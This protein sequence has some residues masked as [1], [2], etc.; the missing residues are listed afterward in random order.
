MTIEILTTAADMVTFS[1]EAEAELRM[2]FHGRVI[3]PNDA[4]YDEARMVF[5]GM[6]DRRPGL[7]IQCSGSADV[8][9]AV[10]FAR[11]HR[12][13]T[14]V[15]GGAHSIAGF[16]A[17]DRGLVID[18]SAMRG[19]WVD[20]VRRV[21]R[22]QGGATWGDVD[23]ETQRVG[24]VV[25]GGVISTPG[26]AGLTLGGGLG[27]VHR[28]FGLSC[29]NLRAVEVVTA[30]GQLIRASESE[31]ADLFWALRGGGGNFGIAT[32]FE[33]DAHVMGPIVMS[34]SPVYPIDQ[35]GTV[36]RGWRDWAMT[37][38]DEI[39]T[40]AMI[41]TFPADPALPPELHNQEVVLIAAIYT[42]DADEG[43]RLCAPIR[44]L[45]VP[46]ADLSMQAPFRFLQSGFDGF[47]AKGVLSSYWKSTYLNELT[48]EAIDFVVKVGSSRVSPFTLVH[49]P[50][51]GGAVSRLGPTDSAFGDRSAPFILSI[52]ANWTDRSDD[53]RQ[54]AWT[55]EVLDEA[56]RFATGQT[57]LNFGGEDDA[58][59]VESAFGANLAR[60]QD[61]K[62]KYD[63]TNIFRL[64]NNISPG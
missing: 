24:L 38:P 11:Q 33:F 30:D 52:D 19:I 20:E 41:W 15:R 60:L 62:R 4:G 40:R 48:D 29:D 21:V 9:D 7:I 39:T 18:L 13:V 36:L 17:C 16:S 45:G 25:P 32:G 56:A 51:M 14:A 28:K 47:F 8:V 26:V 12:L 46:L 63:P 49:I 31:H 61:V 2:T 10:D 59:L 37:V 57:Y 1:E 27:W 22:V 42:G 34:A 5:N 64:N 6:F 35:A 58:E 23:R 3:A 43:E 50:L 54:I 55:R 53:A 44:A